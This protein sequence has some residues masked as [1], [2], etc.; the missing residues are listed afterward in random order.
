VAC[1][2]ACSFL[3]WLR[4]RRF[5]PRPDRCSWHAGAPPPNLATCF[6]GTLARGEERHEPLA[7]DPRVNS[8]M[9][10]LQITDISGGELRWFIQD[11]AAE[12][13]WSGRREVP[14]T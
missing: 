11:P 2:S 9:F 12:S 3:D 6:T 8:M 13:Q 10:S 5:L 7:V 14:G 1:W 4:D